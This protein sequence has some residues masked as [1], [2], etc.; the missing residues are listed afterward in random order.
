MAGYSGTPLPK[1]LG[2]KEGA[3]VA[4]SGAPPEF[5]SALGEL[6]DAV[7]DEKVASAFDNGVLELRLWKRA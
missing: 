4:F 7:D 3:T 5:A 1:K 6:P 2:I